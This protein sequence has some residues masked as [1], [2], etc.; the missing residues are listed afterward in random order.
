MGAEAL[1]PG[2]APMLSTHPLNQ[3]DQANPFRS[4]PESAMVWEIQE[5]EMRYKGAVYRPPSEAD[6]YLLQITYGCSHSKCTFCGSFLDKRF[7]VRPESEVFE[8]IEEAGRTLRGVRRVFLCDGDAMVLKTEKL[9]RYLDALA[10]AF[11]HLQR[12]G[13]YANARDILKKSEEELRTLKDRRLGIVY[14]GL[15]SGSDEILKDVKKGATAEDMIAAVRKAEE[16]GLKASVIMILG[17]GGRA[18]SRMHAEGSARVA[19]A[20]NPRFLSCLML[21]LVPGTPLFEAH[22]RGEFETLQPNERLQ[23]LRWFVEGLELDG[24]IFRANHAS[25]YLPLGGRFPR[26]K[27][28]I[29]AQIDTALSGAAPLRPEFLR[30]L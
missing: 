30:G 16:C 10:E 15:E 12:V 2:S 27:E 20:M 6:S 23:E 8:D 22:R 28:A 3:G 7:S 4:R 29:L 1:I 21:M 13:I 25:N 24:T 19:S 26:D 11:V 5:V 9:L 14:L 18:K 17:L